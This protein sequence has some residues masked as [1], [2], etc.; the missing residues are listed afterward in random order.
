MYRVKIKN[1]RQNIVRHSKVSNSET[2]N[3]CD[4][5]FLNHK[6]WF[7]KWKLL[8]LC[9]VVLSLCATMIASISYAATTT[10][11]ETTV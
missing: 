11:T 2:L 1:Q 7:S 8:I 6:C 4:V 5:R 9:V 10:V 3:D